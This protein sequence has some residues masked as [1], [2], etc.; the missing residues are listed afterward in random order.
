MQIARRLVMVANRVF[1]GFP[2]QLHDVIQR[3]RGAEGI[4]ALNLTFPLGGA[5]ILGGNAPRDAYRI[6]CA[7]HK[8]A[9]NRVV[10]AMRV[11]NNSYYV[12]KWISRRKYAAEDLS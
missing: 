9:G 5:C 3:L 11:K 4:F 6:N 10:M 7:L 1:P 12:N 8:H 2:G